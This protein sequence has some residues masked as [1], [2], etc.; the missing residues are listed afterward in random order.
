MMATALAAAY[1]ISGRREDA[2]RALS[3]LEQD[4]KRVYVSPYGLAQVYAAMGEKRRALDAL[5]RA[6]EEHSFE[7]VFLNV[8]SSFEGL[9]DNPRF[10]QLVSKIGC[11]SAPAQH[12]RSPS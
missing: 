9:H 6:S 5:E 7:L 1:A 10:L 4:A 12:L 3:R 8:D 11:P 2:Q